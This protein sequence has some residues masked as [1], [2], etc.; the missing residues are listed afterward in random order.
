MFSDCTFVTL[1]TV[2]RI[3]PEILQLKGSLQHTGAF[4]EIE[5]INEEPF[6]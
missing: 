3:L 2:R 1:Q 5:E 6:N 4:I